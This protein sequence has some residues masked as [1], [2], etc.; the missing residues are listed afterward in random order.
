MCV[1]ACIA[2]TTEFVSVYNNNKKKGGKKWENEKPT[3]CELWLVCRGGIRGGGGDGEFLQPDINSRNVRR[4]CV[5][6][7]YSRVRA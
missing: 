4:S 3:S 6:M 1:C 7:C 2:Q 5:C